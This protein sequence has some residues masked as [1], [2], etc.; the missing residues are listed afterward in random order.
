MLIRFLLPALLCLSSTLSASEDSGLIPVSQR[1]S[2]T[3]FTASAG[4]KVLRV[5]DL[6]GKVVVV[7]FWT[8]WCPPCRQSLPELAHLQRVGKSKGTLAVLPV[9]M[10][11]DRISVLPKFLGRNEKVLGEFTAYYPGLGKEGVG[12]NFGQEVSAYPTTYI[13][14]HEGRIAW[15]WTGYGQGL[16]VDRINQVLRELQNTTAA[17]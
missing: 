16:L 7:D 9:N 6:K 10:D 11:E 4:G 2:A 3:G 5:A 14:D 8:T 15:R 13:I 12:A 1:K 17:R